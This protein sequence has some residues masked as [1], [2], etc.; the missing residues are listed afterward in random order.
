MADEPASK[1]RSLEEEE[2]AVQYSATKREKTVSNE[3]E[4]TVSDTPTAV[5]ST[6]VMAEDVEASRIETAKKQ[7]LSADSD[8]IYEKG[9]SSPASSASDSINENGEE[10]SE[11]QKRRPVNPI[12]V[13]VV[14]DSAAVRKITKAKLETAGY[15]V[16]VAANGEEAFVKYSYNSQGYYDI[17]LLDIYMPVLDG[18]R[19]ANIIRERESMA[20]NDYHQLI[21]GLSAETRDITV[22]IMDCCLL[23]PFDLESFESCV[24]LFHVH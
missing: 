20:N 8:E 16:D 18:V 12:H 23:K 5:A 15:K 22:D 21:I 10:I 6:N 1:K 13:L 11:L 9:A 3:T 24:R 17:I 14:D 19:L 7:I 2:D 4:A